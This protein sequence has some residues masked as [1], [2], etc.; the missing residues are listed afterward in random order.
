MLQKYEE[1]KTSISD[2]VKSGYNE[3]NN[4]NASIVGTTRARED[5]ATA[6]QMKQ[7]EKEMNTNSTWNMKNYT[8]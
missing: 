2:A 7:L 4:A 3:L 1:Y 8:P 5:A 6:A